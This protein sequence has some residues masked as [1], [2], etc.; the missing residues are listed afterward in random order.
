MTETVQPATLPRTDPHAPRRARIAL[1]HDWC[2]GLR[3]GERVLDSIV[4]A[5]SPDHEIAALFVMFDD[6]RPLTPAVDSLRR[7][8][9]WVGRLPLASTRLR[10]HLFPLYPAAVEDLSRR[11]ETEHAGKPIDIVISTSSAAVK[12]LRP[13][14]GVP[15]L[16]YL[17]SPARYV[18]SLGADYERGSLVRRVGLRLFRERFKRWDA[19]SAAN[20]TCFLANS[21][22][23]A[24]EAQ[25]CYGRGAKV[26]YPAARTEFYT[27]GDPSER[28]DYWLVVAALE[29]YKRVDLAVRAAN[30]TGKRL[31][32][33]GDGTARNELWAIAGPTVEFAGRIG[34]GALR[35]H[36]R[37]ARLLLFPQ[38]EDFGIVAVEAQA[39]GC[40]VVAFRAGGALNT[41]SDGVTGVLFTEQSPSAILNAAASCPVP[42][43]AACRSW[44]ERFSE[45]AFASEFRRHISTMLK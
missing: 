39:C 44:V 14:R 25:R 41:V 22:H 24:S 26:L 43:V 30:E 17:H 40:P 15:H 20:V 23:T 3:G 35:E 10:R 11:V 29:P 28:D 5:L 2:C 38:I 12:G 33:V 1:V 27:P 36:Y 13:P 8:V 34:D 18:W 4:R 31:V 16:C 32:V 21:S 19:A 6:G 9:S 7:V 42:E 45:S 37:R